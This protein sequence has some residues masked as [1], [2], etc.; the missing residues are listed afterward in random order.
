MKRSLLVFSFVTTLLVTI[1]F[2][3]AEPAPAGDFDAATDAHLLVVRVQ[4]DDPADVADFASW[5]EPWE[6]NAER[7]TILIGITRSD[8]ERLVLAG[9]DVEIDAGMT[10]QANRPNV[11]LV[12]QVD[13]IPGYPC[14][15]TVEETFATAEGLATTYP[16]L[17]EWI[18][19]GDS[20]EKVIGIGGYDMNVL[21]LTNESTL[22]PKPVLLATFAIHAREYA[23]AELGTR[24]AEYLVSNYGTDPDVTW[25]LD[26]HEV[27]L[28]LQSNPDGRKQAETGQYWRKNTNQNYCS[29]TSTSRGADLNRNFEFQ[30]GCCGG[31][32][33]SPCSET[34]RGPSPSSEPETQ[35][36]QD[37]GRLI[38]P[39]QRGDPLNDPAPIDA[40]GVYVD[41]HSYS[42][43]V[44]WPWGFTSTAPPNGPALQTLGRKLAYFNAYYP[45]QAIGL[46]PTDGTTDDFFYGEMGV[47][48]FTFEIGTSFF[49]S[50]SAFETTILPDN[51]EALLYAARSARTPYMT[52][53]GPD[54]LTVSLSADVVSPGDPVTVTVQLDDARFNN[55]NGTE[56]AQNIAAGEAYLDL[57]PWNG[58]TPVSLTPTDGAFNSPL[59]MATAALDSSGLSGGRHFVYVRGQDAA[60]N[61]GVVSAAFLYVMSGNEGSVEGYLTDADTSEPLVGTVWQPDTNLS[62][63][64]DPTTGFFSLPLPQGSWTLRASAPYHEDA[65]IANVM[66]QDG[67][68]TP[69]DIPLAPTSGLGLPAVVGAE[70]SL[71]EVAQRTMRIENLGNAPLTWQLTEIDGGYAPPAVLAGTVLLVDDDDNSP[72]VRS[73]YE[74]ALSAL[75]VPYDVFDVGTGAQNGPSAAAMAAYDV[76]IWFS[77]DQFGAPAEAGPNDYDEVQL[78][79]FLDGGGKLFLSSQDYYYDQGSITGFM[80]DYLGVGSMS[81]DN[82]DYTSV[83]GDDVFAGLGPYGLSYPGTDYSDPIT[84][85][86][87]GT[88][89]YVGNNGKNAGVATENAVF[90]PFMW[91]GI[92][93][94]SAANGQEALGAILDYLRPPEIPWLQASPISGAV[95][96][97]GYVDVTLTYSATAPAV[98]E[99]GIYTGTLRV[100]SNDPAAP[101]GEVPVTLQVA[102]NLSPGVISGTLTAAD[103]GLPLAGVV[104]VPAALA[105]TATNPATGAY[106]LTVP[107]GTWTVVA[108]AADYLTTTISNVLVVADAVTPLDVS[109]DPAPGVVEGVVTD[110]LTGDP[111]AATV[112]APDL[113]LST[114]TDAGSGVYSLALPP[115]VWA[116][117]AAATD[118]VTA[119]V[120]VTVTSGLT[121]TQPFALARVTGGVTGSVIDLASGAPMSATV[122][123]PALNLTVTT[124]PATGVYTLTLPAGTWRVQVSAPGFATSAVD[125]TVSSGAMITVDFA[126]TATLEPLYVPFLL[127]P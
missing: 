82:G 122:S 39:D 101:F 70:L 106:T 63:T 48:A 46:Y 59:E 112:S 127:V 89:V 17:A 121:Q 78:A 117:T 10:L 99:N 33:G 113:G 18:D 64:T 68:V 124:D 88:V 21:R 24:F 125:V 109:L 103:T 16:G 43:L 105:S 29:P 28:M 92:Q 73:Y 15:R 12:G 83:A 26:H 62:T 7:G 69:L 74:A 102:D 76:V 61:W 25:I 20:W 56:P 40:T 67:A 22:G 38:F 54:A 66:V 6:V 47:A 32:S 37:Y 13:G 41:V 71:G 126:L 11:P 111:L 90:F 57:P 36:I 110:E 52:P 108:S 5:T 31:S 116:L 4:L 97:G 55:Q 104:E 72:N 94:A 14:Y 45:E 79:Q 58:G 51:I 1:L 91:E 93:N 114:T 115:G 8:Y 119:T 65:M 100:L 50:C 60:G 9:Y 75:G 85:N 95:P 44:L 123:V 81:N 30:W 34:Y 98:I 96:G 2:T 42:E 120:A 118:H 84:P 23:T 19:V 80:S 77:G 53:A 35:A 86:A 49:Q 87:Q 27:H 107:A 3:T